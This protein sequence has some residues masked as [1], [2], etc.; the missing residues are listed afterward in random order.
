MKKDFLLTFFKKPYFP[1]TKKVN[2]FY[3][4]LRQRKGVWA[5][6]VSSEISYIRSKEYLPELID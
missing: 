4:V 5:V 2:G 1:A 3:L 6:G